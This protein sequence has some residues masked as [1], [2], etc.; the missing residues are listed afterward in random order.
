MNEVPSQPGEYT[1]NLANIGKSAVG[2]KYR[3]HV[4]DSN[5]RS[6]APLVLKPAWKPQ[7]DKLGLV[8]EYQLNPARASSASTTINNL[9]LVANY[10]GAKATGCQTKPTGTH[11]K[12]KSLIYWRLG[13]VTLTNDGTWQKVVARLTGSE[14][15][16]PQPGLLEARWEISSSVGDIGS[17]LG[18]SRLDTGGRLKEESDPFADESAAT[19]TTATSEESGSW[20]HVQGARKVVSGKYEAK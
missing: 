15:A 18:V 14:G 5:L 1:L 3:V 17:G 20:V 7:G 9:V 6:T 16:A 13:D 10:T 12:E 8:I 2:F 11:M 4:D 19:P